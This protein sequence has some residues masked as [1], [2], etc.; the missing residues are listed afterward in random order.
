MAR[1]RKRTD[2]ESKNTIVFPSSSKSCQVL[3]S[4]ISS[5]MTPFTSPLLLPI[6]A[7][8][9]QLFCSAAAYVSRKKKKVAQWSGGALKS[10]AAL[11]PSVSALVPAEQKGVYRSRKRISRRACVSPDA[12][13]CV[14]ILLPAVCV[15]RVPTQQN[16]L[17]A[18]HS[19]FI[20]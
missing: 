16:P 6:F 1:T 12:R 13:L 10:A 5:P 9:L 18:L 7:Q 2:G 15:L 20:N 17:P 19:F 4:Y 11:L 8:K 3:L 14:C